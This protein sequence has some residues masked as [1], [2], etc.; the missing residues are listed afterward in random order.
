MKKFSISNGLV[1]HSGVLILKRKPFHT[2]FFFT[3]HLEKGNKP[4]N[5]GATVP[6]FLYETC[7]THQ[8]QLQELI[9]SHHITCSVI[10]T[11]PDRQPLNDLNSYE[12]TV[13]PQ[14]RTDTSCINLFLQYTV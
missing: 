8:V 4:N 11:R 2:L 12:M 13:E 14:N 7:S 6:V 5:S 1:S 3:I 9:Q 10:Y